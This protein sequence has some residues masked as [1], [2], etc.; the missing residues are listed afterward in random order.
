MISLCEAMVV[1]DCDIARCVM[2]LQKSQEEAGGIVEKEC[3]DGKVL[4]VV[5]VLMLCEAMVVDDCDIVRC[6]KV[7]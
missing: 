5:M 1:E 6:V 4:V 7:L 2:V 3:R